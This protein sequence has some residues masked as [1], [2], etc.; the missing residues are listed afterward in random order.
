MEVIINK[1]GH[2]TGNNSGAGALHL[3]TSMEMEEKLTRRATAV[4]QRP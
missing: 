4:L 2:G 1:I 3:M